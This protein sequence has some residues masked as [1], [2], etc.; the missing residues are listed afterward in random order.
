[1]NIKFS[2]ILAISGCMKTD[3]VCF[4]LFIFSVSM[5]V[6]FSFHQNDAALMYLNERYSNLECC[7]RVK[8]FSVIV[9]KDTQV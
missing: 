4:N 7:L 5:C 2:S 6:F 9:N 1:M 3:C 8:S